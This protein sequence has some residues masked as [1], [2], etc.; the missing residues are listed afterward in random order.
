[1]TAA[2][3]RAALREALRARRE[4]LTPTEVTQR[5]AAIAARVITLSQ[6]S[7]VGNIVAFVGVRRE[8]ETWSILESAWSRGAAVWL[9]R[10]TAQ[11][12]V[13]AR[14]ASRAALVPGGFG[15]LEPAPDDAGTSLAALGT[16]L[17]LVLVPGLGF[18]SD[19]ARI[20]FGR[21]YYDR[22]LGPVRSDARIHRVGVC[23]APFLDPP[24]G[25]I[26][27][28]DHDV[29]MHTVITDDAL[30]QCTGQ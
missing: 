2:P 4:R 21:A 14:T 5:S 26:P 19:G 24:E 10:V 15:L 28:A 18:G 7:T 27:M 16:A 30:V 23:F 1:M 17:V 3:G 22:A 8:P 12:L 20:G 11:G 13:F 6:W 9:P 29:P 25:P